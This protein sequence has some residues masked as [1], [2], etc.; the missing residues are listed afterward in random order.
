MADESIVPLISLEESLRLS[1]ERNLINHRQYLNPR[2]AKLLSLIDL[3]RVFVRASGVNL[4]DRDGNQYLDFLSG[5]ASI[6]VG[7]NHPRICAASDKVREW[8]NL[9]EGLSVH[10]GAL[11]HNLATIA[12][13]KLQRV[14]FAN[15]GAEVVDAALKLAVSATGRKKLVACQKGFHGRTIGA[16]S[17][18]DRNEYREPFAPLLA[19]VLFV[20]FGDREIL[21]A[22]LRQGDVAGF[23]VEPIQGEGGIIVPPPGYLKAARDLCANHGTLFI[24]DEIQTGFGRTGSM[25]AV[26]CEGVSPDVLLLGKTLGG[27]IMP[28]SALL[29]TDSLYRACKGETDRTPFHNPT[30][31]GNTRACA[32]ALAT[33]EVLN[34]ERLPERAA[35]SGAY[36]IE[37]LHAL[38]DRQPLIAD[39]R[40]RGLMIG[41]EFAPATEGFRSV[42]TGG[43]INRLSRHF[44]TS[45]IIKQLILKHNII[46]SFTLNDYNVLR[47][48]P[49]LNIEQEHLDYFVE[50]LEEVLEDMQSFIQAAVR[51]LANLVRARLS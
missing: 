19:D 31:G 49:P 24:A 33:L 44:I 15:S 28:I 45:L 48:Q 26:E 4:W 39:V 3:D 50:K 20:P 11:A 47:L 40:G 13:G 51:D 12:P 34:E 23:L 9:V 6:N 21:E 7:H 5:L 32:V 18:M 42:L 25:F 16:L 1:Q 2:L 27:G 41:L 38:K 37:Q 46:T 22:V 35:A 36:L 43:L 17:M 10:A 8:P 30:F 29:T 14:Y